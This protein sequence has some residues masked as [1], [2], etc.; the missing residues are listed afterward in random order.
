MVMN[1][2][3]KAEGKPKV[4]ILE[5][6]L[7]YYSRHPNYF[8]EQLWWWSLGIFAVRCGQSWALIGTII[9]SITLYLVV[10]MTEGKMPNEWPEDRKQLLKAPL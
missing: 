10:H 4:P 9:N 1:E 5:K 3:L 2:K 6:G 7:W 8:G